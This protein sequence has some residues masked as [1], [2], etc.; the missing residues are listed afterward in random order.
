M[1][2]TIFLARL[3]GIFLIATGLAYIIRWK[4]F[5]SMV[6]EM[7][8]NRGV[9]YFII[10]L[11]FVGGLAIFL[12]HDIWNNLLTSLISG[13]GLLMIIEAVFYMLVSHSTVMK[14]IR[15]FNRKTV[16]FIGGAF[17]II[18]GIYFVYQGFFV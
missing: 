6:N 13:I 12:S 17:S 14:I 9:F 15:F 8:I 5:R 11:E 1:S 7:A 2:T 16:F 4:K 18:L 10:L 3:F